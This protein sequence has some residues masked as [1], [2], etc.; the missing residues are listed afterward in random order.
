VKFAQKVERE[1][2]KGGGKHGRQVEGLRR[3][4]GGHSWTFGSEK[5]WLEEIG[6]RSVEERMPRQP[7]C[8][9]SSWRQEAG[10]TGQGEK[11]CGD[12]RSIWGSRRGKEVGFRK[13]ELLKIRFG[14]REGES[15]DSNHLSK[16]QRFLK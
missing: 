16:K 7:S 12:S 11:T 13:E 1:D 10:S 15:V 2:L 6:R 3:K 8:W 14:D 4:K 5:F 9:G